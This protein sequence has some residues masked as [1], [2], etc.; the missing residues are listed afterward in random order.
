MKDNIR[1]LNIIANVRISKQPIL[2]YFLD[3]DKAFDQVECFFLKWVLY[4]MNFEMPFWQ[5]IDLNYG[6]QS[7]KALVDGQEL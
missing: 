7:A 3:A 6:K 5:W 4:K 1:L 2:L